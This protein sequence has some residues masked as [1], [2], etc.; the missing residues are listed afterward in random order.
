MAVR[1][2]SRFPAHIAPPATTGNCTSAL[3]KTTDAILATTAAGDCVSPLQ[4]F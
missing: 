1:D 4:G 3:L 2:L